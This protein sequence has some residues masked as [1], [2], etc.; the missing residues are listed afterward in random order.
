MPLRFAVYVFAAEVGL[1]AS[2]E[3][4]AALLCAVA[5][6]VLIADGV[7]GCVSCKIRQAVPSSIS[8]R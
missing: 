2:T 1:L 5:A 4:H 3:T 6:A 8:V 7:H